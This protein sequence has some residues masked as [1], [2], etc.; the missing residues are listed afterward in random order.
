MFMVK[1]IF[2]SLQGEGINAG[3]PAV[4]CR[5]SGCNMWSGLPKD[6]PES[7]C[8]F[9]DT[10]FRGGTAMTEDELVQEILNLCP[11]G[12]LPLVIFTGGEPALQ[13][14]SSLIKRLK[15]KVINVA[16]ETNGTRCLPEAGPYWITVSPK[17]L[18]QLLV[19]KGHELKL[20]YPHKDIKPQDVEHLDFRYF[21][22]QPI[23]DE[24]Y[25]DNL[26][27]TMNYCLDNPKWRLS[28]QQHKVWGVR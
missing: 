3:R 20:L 14:T 8:P 28:T 7:L 13:L 26:R 23:D 18:S 2:Y 24:N 5:F 19:T 25:E 12:A 27:N 21:S 17:S 11:A 9:C 15:D 4:F 16:V 1:E 10:D 22:L 6:K